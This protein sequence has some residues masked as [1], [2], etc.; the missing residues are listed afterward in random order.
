MSNLDSRLDALHR[1][2]HAALP[3]K[4]VEIETAWQTLRADFGNIDSHAALA[5]RVHRLAGSA[6]SYGYAEVGKA[7]AAADS[8]LDRIRDLENPVDRSRMAHDLFEALQA[9]VEKLDEAMRLAVNT[10]QP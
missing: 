5:K 8:V 7:A 6:A 3:I 2:Y 4:R 10:R 9:A 1:R